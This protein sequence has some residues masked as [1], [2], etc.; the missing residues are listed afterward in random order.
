MRVAGRFPFGGLLAFTVACGSDVT[1]PGALVITLNGPPPALT[2]ST[3]LALSGQVTRTPPAP[4]QDIVVTV[5][6]GTSP[7]SD[8]A[9]V[10]GSF[11]F[12]VGLTAN[13]QNNLSV[14]ASD[15]SGSTATPVGV[16]VR[17]DAL[18]PGLASMTPAAGADG[19]TPATVQIVFTE[20]IVP[21]SVTASLM[22]YGTAISGSATLSADSLTLTF[23][24]S[25]P[26][27]VNA[28]HVL[29]IANARDVAGNSVLSLGG[30]FVTGGGGV[31][32]FPDTGPMYVAFNPANLVPPDLQEVRLARSGSSL[33]GILKFDAPRSLDPSAPNNTSVWMDLD[34]DQDGGTGFVTYRDFVFAGSGVLAASGASSEFFVEIG[35]LDGVNG[36]FAAQYASQDTAQGWEATTWTGATPISPATCGA[37]LGFAVPFSVLGGDDGVFDATIYVDAFDPATGILLEPAPDEGVYSASV[38]GA[39]ASTR[40]PSAGASGRVASAR[41]RPFTLR[42]R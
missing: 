27:A 12:N 6:G 29:G 5:T 3:T 31:M 10:D 9:A 20:P 24:P 23:T 32:A 35:T 8:T 42:S 36:A 22:A 13:A 40:S 39:V 11:G 37:L 26:L 34:A 4:G 2:T 33:H 38:T 16:A 7:V 25:A 19:V 14:T 30:C 18:P 21:S 17:H 15:L 28:V 41:R 1:E